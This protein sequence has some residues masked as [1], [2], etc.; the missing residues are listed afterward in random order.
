MVV[1][2]SGVVQRRVVQG[3]VRRVG[4]PR[5]RGRP[6]AGRPAGQ[7]LPQ[8]P[9]AAGAQAAPVKDPVALVWVDSPYL[10]RGLAPHHQ[11]SASLGWSLRMAP[12][13]VSRVLQKRLLQAG[14]DPWGYPGD[15]RGPSLCGRRARRPVMDVPVSRIAEPRTVRLV[16][17]ARLRDPVLAKLVPAELSDDLAEIEGATSGRLTAVS[18]G[19]DDIDAR[20]FVAGVPHAAF[21]NASFAYWRPRELN[22][23]NGPGR[24]AWYAA[25]EVETALAEVTFHMTRELERVNDFN[26]VVDYAEMFASFPA[27][28]SI[29]A[30]CRPRPP[31][32]TL[33]P[34]WAIQPATPCRIRPDLRGTT[35]S[36]I[37]PCA[38]PA[39][40]A[41]SACG[42]M[43][44]SRWRR[45]TSSG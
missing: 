18:R 6:A 44:C 26:A 10:F 37:R 33:T 29:C 22:R 1:R 4:P 25:L 13:T 27:T 39:G 40:R 30:A 41:S 11:G 2:D 17:S 34:R 31:A 43:P 9:L 38:M 20:E 8:I 45:A 21:I 19:A 24:G 23:F 16:A 7:A 32:C 28:S 35:A 36:S 42:R 12:G 15:D 3:A 14:I 5:R